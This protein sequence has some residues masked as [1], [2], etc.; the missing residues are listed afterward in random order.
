MCDPVSIAYVG[1]AL[2]ATATAAQYDTQRSTA[3]TQADAVR[4]SLDMEQMD[5]ARQQG[6]QQEATAQQMNDHARKARE[7]AALFDTAAGEYGGGNSAA[8]GATIGNL[9]ANEALATISQ[10]GKTAVSESAFG[11]TAAT[12]RANGQLASLSQPSGLGAL[13]S[14]G[15]AAARAAGQVDSIKNPTKKP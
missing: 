11:G 9:Q 7:D 2:S 3:N 10:N 4:R 15:G 5:V 6:Q 13:L 1:L 12:S 8:R 14:I